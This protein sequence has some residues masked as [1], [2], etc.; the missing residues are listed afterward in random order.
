MFIST[1]INTYKK[2][3]SFRYL[4]DMHIPSLISQNIG[5]FSTSE[6]KKMKINEI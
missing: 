3:N 5:W 4:I 6:K 1:I 2:S